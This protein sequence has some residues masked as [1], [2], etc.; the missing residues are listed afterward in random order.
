MNYE[1]GDRFKNTFG[2]IW[3]VTA[4]V[5]GKVEICSYLPGQECPHEYYYF[6]AEVLDKLLR[7]NLYSKMT[8]VA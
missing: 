1:I 6:R 2:T 8:E 4:F 5:G 7:D 3:K